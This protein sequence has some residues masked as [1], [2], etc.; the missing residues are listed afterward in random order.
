MAIL[1]QELMLG[2]PQPPELKLLDSHTGHSSCF[3]RQQPLSLWADT[4]MAVEARLPSLHGTHATLP[5]HTAFSESM[6]VIAT[7]KRS[8]HTTTSLGRTPVVP[9]QAYSFEN[10]PT[11]CCHVSGLL[12]PTCPLETEKGPGQAPLLQKHDYHGTRGDQL[13]QPSKN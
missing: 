6:V 3:R 7:S 10:V 11:H 9:S 8:T 4:V 12:A 13:H 1:P 5:Q 2:L